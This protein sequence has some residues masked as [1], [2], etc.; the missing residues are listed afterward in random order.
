MPFNFTT[1]TVLWNCK[2]WN[3]ENRLIDWGQTFL[4][5]L[6]YATPKL[7]CLT[8]LINILFLWHLLLFATKRVWPIW[9]LHILE[10]ICWVTDKCINKFLLICILFALLLLLLNRF[11]RVRL[12]AT[13]WTAAYQASPSM[14]FSTQELWSGLPFCIRHWH[15]KFKLPPK[16]SLYFLG[17]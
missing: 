12:G 10:Y 3:T 9:L 1:R 13:P 15:K 4:C 7:K 17:S 8:H 11:S 14:G 2:C 5:K 16:P 6:K